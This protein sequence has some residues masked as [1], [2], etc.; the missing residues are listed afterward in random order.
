MNAAQLSGKKQMAGTSNIGKKKSRL[1]N[2]ST[3][4]LHAL[5][6]YVDAIRRYGTSDNY[7]TQTV[8]RMDCLIDAFTDVFEGRA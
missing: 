8:S 5:G 1:L 6:D 7:S 2:L 4:K 3:Y